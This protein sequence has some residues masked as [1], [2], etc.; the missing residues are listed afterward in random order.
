MSGVLDG[1]R[2]IT[3]LTRMTALGRVVARCGRR[4]GTSRVNGNSHSERA[5]NVIQSRGLTSRSIAKMS[6]WSDP[7]RRCVKLARDDCHCVALIQRLWSAVS[8]RWR[9]VT[10]RSFFKCLTAIWRTSRVS[11]SNSIV[12]CLGDDSAR[13]AITFQL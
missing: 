10:S 2:S 6:F 9:K 4:V 12:E 3:G 7:L 13:R 8:K 1:Q 5:A 11:R